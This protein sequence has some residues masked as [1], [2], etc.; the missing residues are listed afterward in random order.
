M[1]ELLIELVNCEHQPDNKSFLCSRLTIE[2]ALWDPLCVYV[3]VL[4]NLR[5]QILLL[6]AGDYGYVMLEFGDQICI[7]SQRRNMNNAG[8]HV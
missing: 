8:L 6:F 7:C 4:F 3:N 1:H 2:E 5:D